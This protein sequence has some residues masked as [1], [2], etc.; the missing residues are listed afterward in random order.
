MLR[1]FDNGNHKVIVYRD[2]TPKGAVQSN[3]AIIVEGETGMIIDPGGGVTFTT[4]FSKISK[5]LPA[6]KFRYIL[7]TH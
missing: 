5:E 4:L 7:L 6:P 1:L 3:Q 2:L